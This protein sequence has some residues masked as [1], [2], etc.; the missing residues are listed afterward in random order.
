MSAFIV[1]SGTMDKCVAL[2]CRRTEYGRAV[3]TIFGIRTGNGFADSSSHD[4]CMTE[5]GRRLYALNTEAVR[6]RY[7]DDLDELPGPVDSN[8]RS[9]ARWLC[10]SYTGPAFAYSAKEK[11]GVLVA[12]YKA[13]ECLIYQCSEGDVFESPDYK[14]LCSARDRIAA[15][16]LRESADYEAAPWGDFPG[17]STGG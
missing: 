8:G 13:I 12:A 7:G 10:S 5:I 15:E 2:I 9:T 11:R 1:S 4:G 6:Q 14:E 3:P 16:L 17:R